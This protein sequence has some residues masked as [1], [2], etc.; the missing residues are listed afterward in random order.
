MIM[1]YTIP[2]AFVLQGIEGSIRPAERLAGMFFRFFICF[3]LCINHNHGRITQGSDFLRHFS[4]QVFIR[5]DQ[6]ARGVILAQGDFDRLIYKLDRSFNG[7]AFNDFF[8]VFCM[9]WWRR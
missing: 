4:G 8:S 5:L 2:V 6:F 9:G 1:F 3:V 7:A